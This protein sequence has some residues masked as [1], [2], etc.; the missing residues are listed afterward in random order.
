MNAETREE[1][2]YYEA[3][4]EVLRFAQRPLTTR[5]ITDLA[6]E[7][8]LIAPRSRT[9]R[10]SMAARLYT[11]VGNSPVLIRLGLPG[12]GRAKQGS[13]RWALRDMSGVGSDPQG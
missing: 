9:P 6:I 10:S 5:E 13:V 8:G 7:R 12:N 4:L 1:M 3:A 2:T 11:R